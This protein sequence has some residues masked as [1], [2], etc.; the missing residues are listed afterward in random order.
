MTTATS[1]A[2]RGTLEDFGAEEILQF[3]AG[4]KKTGALVLSGDCSG[5]VWFADGEV[6]SAGR[7]HEPA[8][9]RG[10]RRRRPRHGGAVG[11]RLGRCFCRRAAGQRARVAR[12]TGSE[13][14]RSPDRV[15]DRR[16]GLRAHRDIGGGFRVP[17]RRTPP[18]HRRSEPHRRRSDL[19]EPRAA[20][21]VARGRD[22]APLDRSGRHDRRRRPL[23]RTRSR[24]LPGRLAD[25]RSPRR[26]AVVADITR[27]LGAS[28][29]DVCATLH[30][31]V[32]AGAARVVS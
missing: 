18:A 10:S 21:S 6:Y 31:L 9:P 5:T 26:H 8:V 7:D 30:R 27:L 24:A 3:L 22:G 23:G 17:R 20:R 13:R 11:P 19:G 29:F 28:A 12:V 14:P 15:A 25:R 16:H 2:L 4:T 32:V 1:A